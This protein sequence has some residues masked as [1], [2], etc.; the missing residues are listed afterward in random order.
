M[1]KSWKLC[2]INR[3]DYLQMGQVH[4]GQDVKV[5]PPMKEE[6]TRQTSGTMSCWLKILGVG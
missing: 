3:E 6:V 1:A 5:E 4:N 2:D